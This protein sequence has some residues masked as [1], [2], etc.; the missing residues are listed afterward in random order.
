MGI[1][2]RKASIILNNGEII[3]KLNEGRIVYNEFDINFD[4]DFS[5]QENCLLEDLL[6]I[7]Y[8]DGYLLDLGWYPEFD[9][10]GNFKMQVIKDGNWD[11]PIYFRE[12]R[13]K[14]DL[15]QCIS[16]ADI[17][18]QSLLKR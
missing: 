9:A 5:N 8:A 13:E 1:Q 4:E 6:Q 2:Y 11:S 16:D 3:M 15:I 7:S 10:N 14:N 18:I 17:F 12:C